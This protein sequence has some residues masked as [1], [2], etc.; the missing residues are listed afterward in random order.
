MAI[1]VR[2]VKLSQSKPG[3]IEWS[4]V[5]LCAARTSPAEGDLYLDD[6]IHH[7]LSQ[8]FEADFRKMGFFKKNK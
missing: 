3:G 1:R 8:K 4:Y 5:A 6:N 2:K 7:A